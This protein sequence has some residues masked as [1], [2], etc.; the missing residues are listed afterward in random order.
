[1]TAT[2]E[3]IKQQFAKVIKYS[4]GI[5]QV[6][7]DEIFE[8]WLEAKR[9]IIDAW[10]GNFIIETAQPVTF[11][12][13]PS[14]KAKRLDEFINL[15]EHQYDNSDLVNFLEDTRRDFFE[16]HLSNDYKCYFGKIIPKG[17]KIIKAFKYFEDDQRVLADLQNQASMILQED[18]VTGTLCLSVHPLDYLS[19]SENT[20]H[21]RSCHALDGDYR[22]GNLSYMVDS[23][24][25]VCYLRGAD[26]V[27]LPS[28]SPEVPWNSKKW[29]ML[30][31]LSDSWNAMF[32][33][34]QYPFFSPT[35]LNM[36]KQFVLP[37]LR[38]ESGYRWSNWHDDYIVSFRRREDVA[39]CMDSDLC[40]R[41]VAL[42]G[43]VYT[44]KELVTDG[45]NALHFNDLLESSFYVPYYCW[46]RAGI[47]IKDI[48]FSIGKAVSCLCCNS[49]TLTLSSSMM[50]VD[51]EEAHGS[52]ENDYFSYC[53]CCQRRTLRE[54]MYYV[55]GLDGYVCPECFENETCR[56]E[57]CGHSWYTCD[58]TYNHEAKM[59]LCPYCQKI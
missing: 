14:E 42:K 33:G 2:I 25:I 16:N 9:A 10:K 12:L 1:M 20:Y 49:S 13:S 48:H 34:R 51:C 3:T 29:R 41:H 11:E 36:I 26:N 6:Q 53:E 23:A 22:A 5:S 21:W 19:S 55:N 31:F 35:A 17:T 24:T 54:D 52:G 8:Q 45:H 58:I 50:C 37:Y 59:Y 39:N 32:A 56:C 27:I 40:G 28:F 46:C 44:M 4:Q 47:G 15:V 30:L 43:C 38:S 57:S 18:K 7:V